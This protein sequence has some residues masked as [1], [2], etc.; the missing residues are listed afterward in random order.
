[1]DIAYPAKNL[2]DYIPLVIAAKEAGEPKAFL[3]GIANQNFL[4]GFSGGYD[5]GW[6]DGFK[7]GYT[8][9]YK[10]GSLKTGLIAGIIGGVAVIGSIVATAVIVKNKCEKKARL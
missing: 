10:A 2:G 6:N 9:G 8:A 5:Y 4:L 1:M 7:S 3:N